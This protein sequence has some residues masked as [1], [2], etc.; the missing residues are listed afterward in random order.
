MDIKI[1]A[2]HFE[3]EQNLLKLIKNKINKLYKFSDQIIGADVYLKLDS[4]NEVNKIIEIRLKVPD[5]D[6]FVK[7]KALSFEAAIDMA[8]DAIQRQLKKRKEKIKK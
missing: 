6:L 8:I 5:W 1:Q 4:V 7:K 2:I 3:P